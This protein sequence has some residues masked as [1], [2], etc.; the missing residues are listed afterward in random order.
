VALHFTLAQDKALLAAIQ[1]APAQRL[2]ALL[3]FMAI[4]RLPD[5]AAVLTAFLGL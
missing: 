3:V 5:R 2:L 1:A 4:R